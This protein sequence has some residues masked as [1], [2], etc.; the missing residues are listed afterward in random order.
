MGGLT[1][2]GNVTNS[3]V[4]PAN[5]LIKNGLGVDP[6][7]SGSI[8]DGSATVSL[9]K[10]QN[11]TL[12]LNG[13]NT[14]SGGTIVQGGRV[15]SAIGSTSAQGLLE[16]QTVTAL[17]TGDVVLQ[18][19]NL[20]LNAATLLNAAQN[21]SEV[22]NSIDYLLWGGGSGL[23]I[24]VSNTAYSNGVLLPSNVTSSLRA[25]TQNAGINNLTVDAPMLTFLTEGLYQV[26]GT[27]TFS[28]DNTVLRTAGARVFFSGKVDAAG[29]TITKTGANDLVLTI[30]PLALIRT[31]L[32]F[33]FVSGGLLEAR[34]INGGSNPFGL[35]PTIE[36]NPGTN[37]DA[38]GLRLLTD[39]DTTNLSELVT[40]YANTNL[41]IGSTL[42]V[43]SDNF[44]S[45]GATRVAADRNAFIGNNSWKT[46]QINNLEVGGALGSP[47]VYFVLGVNNSLRVEG[48]TTFLR[49]MTLQVD[50][51]QGLV[52]NGL[53]SG[54]GTLNRRSNGGT[55]YIN[56]DNSA[57]YNGGTF[58]TGG[59]RN[60]FGSVLGNQI[61]LSETAKLGSGHVFVG[62]LASL[63][64]NSAG[65]LQ[66]G[67][68][69]NVSGNLSW[70]TNLSLAANLSPEQIRLRSYGLGGI[71]DSA[72][73]YYLNGRNP[74]SASLAL[75][76]IYTHALNM[77]TFGD[78]MWFLGSMTNGVGANGSY[79]APTLAPGLAD[80]YRLGSGGN[81]LFFG[82]NGNANVLTD[83]DASKSSHLIVG[84]PMTVQ[85]GGPLAGGSGS[86]VLL[87]NQNYTGTTIVNRSSTLDFRGTLTTSAMEIYGTVNVGGEA[88]TFI[89]P[90]TAA[91]I[92]VTLRPGATVRIDNNSG[93][94]QPRRLKVA[95]PMPRHSI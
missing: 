69:I 7:F 30:L 16:A 85:N 91:N 2:N 82:S 86:I 50:G 29:K 56:A 31:T 68:N 83:I 21:L 48:T 46:I 53:I 17:G 90:V 34:A 40:T 41:R 11:G 39:G 73:D 24:T 60:Y 92:P 20:H 6:T 25:V 1:G 77:R 35:N 49:D 63:Q 71:Q 67:Q 88:G 54:N 72:T 44:V 65:N 42:P 75:G 38:R 32:G 8:N 5:L 27:S 84:T 58:F 62:A 74:A 87:Q 79:D 45:S 19:G 78:G 59:G 55:L 57:G 66:A 33:G 81:T 18:G 80:T 4:N 93:V 22:S 14:Y 43:S 3:S 37:A 23:N 26:N 15:T 64:I 89:N 28:Q 51:G 52:L 76:T 10:T 61:T 94:L 95:G 9:T 13:H 12:R 70:M 36:V 47:Q